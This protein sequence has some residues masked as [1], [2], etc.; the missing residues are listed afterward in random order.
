MTLNNPI[1]L[2]FALVIPAIVAL[3]LLKLRRK[4]RIVSSTFFWMEMVQ[5]LQANVPFQRLRWNILLFLQVLIAAGIIAAMTDLSLKG[6]MNEGQRTIFI[7]DT[8]SSMSAVESG[9]SR[10][11]SALAEIRRYSERLADREQVMIIEAGEHA[12]MVLDF[13]GN[14][15]AIGRALDSLSTHD[16][17][18]DIGTAWALAQSKAAEVDKPVIVIASDFSGIS[19]ELF[20][21]ARFPVRFL[22]VGGAAK[23]VAITDFT[24]S[25]F[26]QSEQGTSVNAFLVMRN[27]LDQPISFNAEFYVDGEL[28][29]VRQ[30][31]M[32]AGARSSKLFRD[33]PFA[34]PEGSPGVLEARLQVD[35]D[36]AVDNAAYAMP[37][38]D[39]AMS[40]LLV[41]QDPFLSL[42]LAGLPGTRLYQ[43][44]EDKYAPGADF[45]LTF[46]SG[47]APETLTPGSY[48]FFKPPDREY[49]P[50]SVGA[51]VQAPQVTDWDDG[52]PLLRFVNPGSF[53]V[54][55]AE[56]IEPRAGAMTL[57]DGSSTP[58]M[59]YGEHNYLRA[60]VFPFGLM[61]E[62]TDLMTQPTF[63]ILMFNIISFFRSYA[64]SASAG[65][66]TE[67]IGAVRVQT[68]GEKVK[69]RGPGGVEL[70]F[71][72]DAGHAFLDVDKVGVYTMQV[73]GAP[74]DT[75]RTIVANFFDEAES[76]IAASTPPAVAEGQSSVKKF[77]VQAE[78]RIWKWLS[79][80]AL[81]ILTIEWVF[82][83]RK[84]F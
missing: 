77:E 48:A 37:S 39:E 62:D 45:D 54:L 17:R 28:V 22:Q 70:E 75:R 41:G 46:F 35:D 50:C 83:H 53:D 24:V 64:D 40:V 13:T 76:D 67:G 42:V 11:Q 72:I 33:V 34:P 27:F 4:K 63:P 49:L 26:N 7:V 10:L 18:T 58:L 3:Y 71:P 30:V 44:S 65:L 29:D 36:L 57:I 82:Y 74:E 6:S 73:E 51:A 68:L 20:A 66:R 14:Q 19:S 55:S 8:S 21:D 31:D 84:G 69:V 1:A 80:I 56:K 52:H 5:D 2:I 9:Q 16:T 38:P 60:V 47:W 15:P 61:P 32:E 43:I 25:G 79:I 12:Q 78:R 59:I 23:N 81:A